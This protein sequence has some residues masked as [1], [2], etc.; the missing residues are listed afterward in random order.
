[1]KTDF[2]KANETAKKNAA[3]GDSPASRFAFA[4]TQ[5][6][7]AQD[8]HAPSDSRMQDAHAAYAACA[9]PP[10]ISGIAVIRMSGEGAFE[11]ADDVFTS[12]SPDPVNVAAMK[13]YTCAFGDISY[14][15]TGEVIDSVIL[16]KFTA[17]HSYTGED[18]IEISCHGG[19]AVKKNILEALFA[20]GARPALPG[21]FS[22]N[23]F[24]NGKMDLAQAEAVMDLI[25]ATAKKASA[26]A[27]HQMSGTLSQEIRD[28]SRRLYT[29][30]SEIEMI[31]EFPEHEQTNEA[32]GD[33]DSQI[34]DI[35]HH[36]D[37]L[38]SSFKKGRILKEGLTV[39]IA[40]K[41]NAG[42]SSMLNT[43][44]GYD[45]AIVT[46]TPGT[47]RDTIEEYVDI[48]GLPVRLIDTAGL[49]SP[50]DEIEK[51]GIGRAKEAIEKADLVFWIFG[52]S[53]DDMDLATEESEL[54][55][56]L[57]Y[58]KEDT[59]VFIIG[60]SDITPFEKN[61][62]KLCRKFPGAQI[63]PFS[64]VTKEGVE[65]V[66]A[67]IRAKYDEYGAGS[68]DEII[69]T[70]SRHYHAILKAKD[71]IELAKKSM[72]MHMP[73]DLLSSVLRNAAES[74][75][76]ITGDEVTQELVDEIFSRFCIGK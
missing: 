39:V 52:D 17:P 33:I 3:H 20:A 75:A 72:S 41:P 69:I 55:E 21:E 13:G 74:L 38:I 5:D 28:I 76:Q 66:R 50:E 51:S 68:G 42:K 57:S 22:R 56:I 49:R 37:L 2:D 48:E 9:S 7:H 40:G 19:S 4:N 35:G 11:I 1:M 43:L 59:L 62:L 25:S 45:R 46:S 61:R 27:L 73:V 16:T 67:M 29:A 8:A 44:A 31:V 63:L 47:T 18:T 58:R 60:K 10:G 54:K 53:R 23:A 24:L 12:R 70:N 36:L 6:A 34:R 15:G 32:I 30:M 64:S 71:A 14:P 65:A 26:E